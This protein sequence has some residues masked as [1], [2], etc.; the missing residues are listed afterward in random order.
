M[1]TSS[2]RGRTSAN[3]LILMDGVRVTGV[4]LSGNIKGRNFQGNFRN[5]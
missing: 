3:A 5:S 4:D 1:I 2:N